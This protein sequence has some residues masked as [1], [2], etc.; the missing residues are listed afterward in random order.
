MKDNW[1]NM[2]ALFYLP[3]L[4]ATHNHKVSRKINA[5]RE[6]SS[7]TKNRQL[8]AAEKWLNLAA[9]IVCQRSTM[10]ADAVGYHFLQASGIDHWKMIAL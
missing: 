8:T 1:F 7:G 4:G 2:L 10:D 9:V 5:L 6:S 3:R